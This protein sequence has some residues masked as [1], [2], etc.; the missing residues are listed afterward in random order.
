LLLF[1]FR[2]LNLF[3]A[4]A[5]FQDSGKFHRK[6]DPFAALLVVFAQTDTYPIRQV[7]N[8]ELPQDCIFP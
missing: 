8:I 6:E 3:V 7:E 4:R 1:S 5:A 2:I